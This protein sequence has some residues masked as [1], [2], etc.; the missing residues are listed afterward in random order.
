MTQG[1]DA[2]S[3]AVANVLAIIIHRESLTI[4]EVSPELRPVIDRH[5][6][7]IR[8]RLWANRWDLEHALEEPIDNQTRQELEYQLGIVALL[9]SFLDME[10][11]CLV[12]RTQL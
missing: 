12:K 2:M 1:Y 10:N 6:E 3:A 4:A 7:R 5:I 9:H 11:P 8:D